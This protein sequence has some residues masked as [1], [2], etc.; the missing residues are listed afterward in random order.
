MGATRY[1]VG[2]GI[3]AA[4][5]VAAVALFGSGGRAAQPAAGRAPASKTLAL[6]RAPGLPRVVSTNDADFTYAPQGG[7]AVS[8]LSEDGSPGPG[9]VLTVYGAAVT[10]TA[11]VYAQLTNDEGTA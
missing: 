3:L 7:T 5:A 1:V 4:G 9:L 6:V 8:S 11:H 2:A 10:G